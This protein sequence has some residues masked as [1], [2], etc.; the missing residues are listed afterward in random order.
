VGGAQM[1][2]PWGSK[3]AE[4]WPDFDTYE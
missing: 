3:G 2:E 4:I 1:E